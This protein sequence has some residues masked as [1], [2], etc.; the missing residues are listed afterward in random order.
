LATNGS[1]ASVA[2]TLG[3]TLGERVRETNVGGPLEI[4]EDG[5]SVWQATKNGSPGRDTGHRLK[6]VMVDG[7]TYTVAHDVRGRITTALNLDLTYD[8]NNRLAVADTGVIQEYYLYDATGA[9][10]AR[11][12]DDGGVNAL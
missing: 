11:G 2:T 5:V 8:N 1:V 9:M 12:D 6:G 10:V 4:I 3:A 7:A